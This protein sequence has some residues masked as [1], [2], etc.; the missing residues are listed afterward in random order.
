[1]KLKSINEPFICDHCSRSVEATKHGTCRD[2]CP[3]CLYGK[4]VDEDLPGDRQS[5]CH[6]LMEPAALVP[7][8]QKGHQIYYRCQKCG[9]ERVNVSAPDDLYEGLISLSL[10]SH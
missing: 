3:Y 10:E 7:H 5:T 9:I 2:H 8:S 4:H 6:G 1:M